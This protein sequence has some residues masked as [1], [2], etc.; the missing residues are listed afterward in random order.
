MKYLTIL[1]FALLFTQLTAFSQPCLPEGIV[2]T[3]QEQIDNFQTNY[4]GCTEIEGEV[5][6][7]GDDITNLNGLYVLTSIGGD[8][9][10]YDTE[11][12][13][14]IGLNNITSVGGNLTIGQFWDPNPFLNWYGNPVL[15]SLS[16]LEN[17]NSID[18]SLHIASN[19]SL[20]SLTGLES[21]TSIGDDLIIGHIVI[22]NWWWV[23]HGN[24]LLTN[25]SALNN[26]D[27][28]GGDISIIDN[29]VLTN[30]T[31]LEGLTSI[32]GDFEIY[33]NDVLTSLTGLENLSS[34]EGNLNIGYWNEYWLE[35]IG[36]PSLTNLS[37]LAQLTSTGGVF[38]HNNQLL[39]SLN[40]LEGLTFIGGDLTIGANEILSDLTGLQN[41]TSIAG[42]LCIGGDYSFYV[43]SE[44]TSL[45]GLENLTSVGGAIIIKRTESLSSLSG[46]ENIDPISIDSLI[47]CYNWSLSS[48]EVQNIC[49][50]LTNPD[51]PVEIHANDVGCNNPWEIAN[52]CGYLLPCLPFG[53]YYFS[54]QADIDNFGN[55]SDCTELEGD[56]IINGIEITNLNGLIG[57]TSIIGDLNIYGN[58]SLSSLSGFDNLTSIGGNLSIGID[59]DN[60][61]HSLISLSGLENLTSIEGSLQIEG[62]H[63]LTSLSGL[64]S[65]SSIGGDLRILNNPELSTCDVQSICDY[66]AA[67]VG[68]IVIHDNAPGCNS[69]EEVEEVCDTV[70]IQEINFENTFTISPNP[71][72][73]NAVISYTLNECSHTTLKILDLSG[74]EII[75]LVNEIQQQGEQKIEF[76]TSGLPAGVYFCVL[77]IN[78]W[79]QTTKLIK[80]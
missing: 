41:I 72:E 75:T 19:D 27:F 59:D 79:I 71:L 55:Y 42:D 66:L 48:C 23:F 25:L 39:A 70:S 62:N 65:V 49:D 37:A 36:N 74:R 15:T 12:T 22:S 30:L 10:I 64:E 73:L 32:E 3:T 47:I 35:G 57:V 54:C 13:S 8:L 16:G 56:V 4:P 34:V 61:N 46:L 43:N 31:G 24:P 9:G 20:T 14:L 18:G 1:I 7:N 63:S 17:L 60:G 11:L 6:I 78:E 2:F 69:P 58:Y 68:T 26:L 52:T 51:G 44:L 29:A 53:N 38:I 45:T 80:L 77:K 28:I 21:L 40:G 50:Y 67:P 76:N 33:G 5:E